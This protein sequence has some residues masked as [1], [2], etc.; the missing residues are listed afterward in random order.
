MKEQK[1]KHDKRLFITDAVR[2]NALMYET[3]KQ[4]LSA[5]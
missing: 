4:M 1:S 2:Q 5:F 3:E